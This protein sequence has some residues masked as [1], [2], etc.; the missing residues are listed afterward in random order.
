MFPGTIIRELEHC[1][2]VS[3]GSVEKAAQVVL[4]RQESGTAITVDTVLLFSFG[5][6]SGKI[7]MVHIIAPDKVLLQMKS[8]DIFLISP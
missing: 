6:C 8:I 5:T 2:A 4:Y 1:L 7:H 3:E